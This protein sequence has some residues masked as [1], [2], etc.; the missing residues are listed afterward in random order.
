MKK[1][2]L[3]NLTFILFA[4]FVAI[5]LQKIKLKKQ[6]EVLTRRKHEKQTGKGQ[7]I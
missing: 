2:Q 7:T 1:H 6:T 4:A 3:M 5:R